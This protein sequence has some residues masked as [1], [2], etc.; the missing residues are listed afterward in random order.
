ME[1][2]VQIHG[3]NTKAICEQLLGHPLGLKIT[4]FGNF[5]VEKVG[6]I[7]CFSC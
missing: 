1:N 2:V 3:V 5:Y 4:L 7:L 6:V